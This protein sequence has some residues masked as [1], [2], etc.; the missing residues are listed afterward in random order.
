[1]N[2]DR[3]ISIAVVVAGI[4]EEYQVN[5]ISGINSFAKENNINIAYFAAFG[6]MLASKR[7]DIGEYSIYDLID[8]SRFDGALLMTNTVNDVAV[9]ERITDK[10]KSAGIPAV[11]FD[12]ADYPEFYNIAINNSG[13][14]SELIEHVINEHNAKVINYISGPLSNPEARARYEA[15]LNVMGEHELKVEDDRVYFG[16]FRTHDGR[17]A[18]EEFIATGIPMP[19]AIICA[20][21]A[22]AL[23]AV[24]ALEKNGYKVPDDIIVTGFD[25]TYSAR[26][27]CPALSSVKRPLFTAGYKACS[28]VYD[29]L[30]GGDPQK[31]ILLDAYPVF[32]ES[33]GCS[34][35]D[36]DDFADYK[37]RTYR[38]TETTNAN[39]SMLNRLTARLAETEDASEH[40]DVIESFIEEIG[41]E[42]F[43]LCLTEDWQDAY[44]FSTVFDTSIG[45]YAGYMTAP[46]IWDKGERRSVGYYPSSKMFPESFETGGNI[47]YF[48]PLHFRER[49]LGYYIMTNGDFP[50]NSLLCHTLTMNI[51]NSIENIR[52]L[53]HLN[54]TMD[55]LNRLYVIDPLCNI[56]NRNGFINIADDLFRECVADHRTVMLSFVDMDGLKFINDNYGHNEGDMAIQRLAGVIQECCGQSSICAR[57]GGDEFIIFFS[58]INEGFAEALERKFNAK[59]ESSNASIRKPYQLSASIGSIVKKLEEGDTLYGIIQ[60]A[61]EKMY[62]IK[63]QKKRS[64]RSTDIPE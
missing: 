37:K 42:R 63:K 53:F 24:T 17:I 10:V 43:S 14:M 55:E 3:I 26:N 32:S 20:N 12:C 36:G 54:K 1:M 21:D 6:G 38:K 40:F 22:M 33:C 57:F 19:D 16:E 8:F 47:S 23:T 31:E 30:N 11:V 2:S 25:Y 9:K 60:Q 50:I 41:C 59:I 13:A 51:S 4:D 45:G 58:S 35:A 27:Y 48:L 15:F 7:F 49:C 39:I 56:Y 52:K 46:L 5:I 34:S 29:I 28:I 64:R 44:N 18:V 61:D 62:E